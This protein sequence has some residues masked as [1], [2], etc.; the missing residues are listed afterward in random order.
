LNPLDLELR[1][2]NLDPLEHSASSALKSWAISSASLEYNLRETNKQTNKKTLLF[3]PTGI[4]F[5]TSKCVPST[6]KF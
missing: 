6:L 5:M 1:E 4:E 3:V 2:L